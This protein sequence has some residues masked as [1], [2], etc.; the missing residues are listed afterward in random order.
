MTEQEKA[1]FEKLA[2]LEAEC[3]G[4]EKVEEVKG[5]IKTK[6]EQ[7]EYPESPTILRKS[8]TQKLKRRKSK[9]KNSK[10]K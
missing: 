10:K 1:Q 3:G 4:N 7:I 6:G 5:E 9:L 8:K 2:K